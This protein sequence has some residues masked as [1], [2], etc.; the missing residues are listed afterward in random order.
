M[1]KT[2]LIILSLTCFIS[3]EEVKNYSEESLTLLNQIKHEFNDS[4]GLF[5]IHSYGAYLQPKLTRE[6]IEGELAPFIGNDVWK[7][8]KEQREL[9]NSFENQIMVCNN[10]IPIS[11]FQTFI[12]EMKRK[13][14]PFWENL[15]EK[16]SCV[17]GISI[18]IFSENYSH[19]FVYEYSMYGAL[20]GGGTCRVYKKE[21]LGWVLVKTFNE[22]VS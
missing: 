6:Q 16:F 2:I 18:P 21:K 7:R 5:L 8:I 22:W 13:D 19:A 10:Q 14:L 9:S 1:K 4:S 3:C 11:E 20:A 12:E 17:S 15:V